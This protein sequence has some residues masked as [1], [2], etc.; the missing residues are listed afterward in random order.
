MVYIIL[1]II[2]VIVAL[3]GFSFSSYYFITYWKGRLPLKKFLWMFFSTWL[4]IIVITAIEFIIA[5]SK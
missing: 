3:T 1:T 5:F 2:K 4:A